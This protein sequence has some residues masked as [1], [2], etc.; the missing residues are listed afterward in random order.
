MEKINL[1][2]RYKDVLT[3]LEFISENNRGIIITNGEFIR[4]ILKNK[5]EQTTPDDTIQAIDYEGGPMISVGNILAGH[6]VK[7]IRNVQLIEFEE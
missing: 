3:E 6:K 7:R 5:S 2:S 4:T 1:Q